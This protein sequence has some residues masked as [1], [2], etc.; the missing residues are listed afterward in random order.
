[1]H[2]QLMAERRRARREK[3]RKE[4]KKARLTGGEAAADGHWLGLVAVA[5]RVA[6]AAR[7][8]VG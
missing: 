2:K 6:V 7:K 5:V 8:T 3:E 1:M 4:N